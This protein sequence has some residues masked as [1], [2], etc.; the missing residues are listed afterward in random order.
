VIPTGIPANIPSGP[1]L[2]AA[3]GVIFAIIG[4][5]AL[6]SAWVATMVIGPRGASFLVVP[7]SL[8]FAA[9]TITYVITGVG[10]EPL[11]I[12]AAIVGGATLGAVVQRVAIGAP[13]Q[14]MGVAFRALAGMIAGGSIGGAVGFLGAVAAGSLAPFLLVTGL[15]AIVGALIAARPRLS[16]SP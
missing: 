11:V 12:G 9:G 2:M 10:L 7:A 4:I 15:G 16:S 1:G 6:V 8:G 5:V 14:D 3:L 13:A